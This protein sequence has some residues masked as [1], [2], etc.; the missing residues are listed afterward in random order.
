MKDFYLFTLQHIELLTSW[1]WPLKYV[2]SAWNFYQLI[3]SS[4]NSPSP[5][6]LFQWIFSPFLTAKTIFD[7]CLNLA[8]P[9][10]HGA[11]KA[12]RAEM[13]SVHQLA[14]QPCNWGSS[15]VLITKENR[16]KFTFLDPVLQQQ[17]CGLRLVCVAAHME[18]N[19][20]V[21][22]CRLQCH[23]PHQTL[24]VWD[25]CLERLMEVE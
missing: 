24:K 9:L 21:A 16:P 18:T 6:C 11:P 7:P 22:V 10:N 17:I 15:Q 14:P 4:P 13:G 5:V 2:N 23:F 8:L 19:P 3:L 1:K 20:I 12:L 25:S